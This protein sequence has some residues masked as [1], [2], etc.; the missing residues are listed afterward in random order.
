VVVSLNHSSQA[1][2]LVVASPKIAPSAKIGES[3]AINGICLT[4]VNLNRQFMEFDISS[5]SL[6]KTTLRDLKVGEK[7]NLERALLFSDRLGGH[8]VTG[9]V[10]GIGEIRNRLNQ[11][12]G[13]ELFDWAGDEEN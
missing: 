12:K 6:K 11:E 10:D 7:V 9:H 1:A 2:R 5:E 8:L 3:I 4:L 13:F